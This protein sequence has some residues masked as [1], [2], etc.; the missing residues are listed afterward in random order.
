MRGKLT[1]AQKSIIA[2]MQDGAVIR[3][4]TEEFTFG[5]RVLSKRTIF[6]LLRKRAIRPAGDGAFGRSQTYL[7]A[8]DLAA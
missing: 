2:K 8:K 1:P 4:T 7:L 3:R 5:P 6:S